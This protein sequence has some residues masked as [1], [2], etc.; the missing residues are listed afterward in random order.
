M[1]IHMSC[2]LIRVAWLVLTNDLWAEMMHAISRQK[3]WRAGVPPWKPS[4]PF[5]A[6]AR[7]KTAAQ[8]ASDSTGVRNQ[9]LLC[10]ATEMSGLANCSSWHHLIWLTPKVNQDPINRNYQSSASWIHVPAVTVSSAQNWGDLWQTC[11]P[12]FLGLIFLEAEPE[13][14]IQVQVIRTQTCSP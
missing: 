4:V 3:Q 5:P 12:D 8:P 7:W 13:M 9:P 2:T 1:S 11:L 10:W 6:A 14:R